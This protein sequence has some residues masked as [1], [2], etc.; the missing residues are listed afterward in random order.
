MDTLIRSFSQ[1][2]RDVDINRLLRTLFEKVLASET[3]AAKNADGGFFSS[4]W[5]ELAQLIKV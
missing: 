3:A 1:I 4:V 5:S 2:A